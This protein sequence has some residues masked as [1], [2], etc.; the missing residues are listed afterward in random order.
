MTTPVD[1]VDTTS[2]A[3]AKY[4]KTIILNRIF[5]LILKMLGTMQNVATAQADRLTFLTQWQKGYTDKMNQVKVFLKDDSTVSTNLTADDTTRGNLN[6]LNSQLTEKLRN[7]SS[8]VSD[9]SKATQGT[10]NQSNDAVN[11]QSTMGTS[12]L[13]ELSTILSSIYR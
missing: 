8:I 13:Q 11:Q 12:I 7:Q 9:E 6:Q 5:E 2:L 3:P 4:N 10:V 1:P